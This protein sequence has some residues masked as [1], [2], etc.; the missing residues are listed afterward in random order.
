M[1]KPIKPSAWNKYT[2]A[3][4]YHRAGF[5]P[6]PDDIARALAQSPDDAV[7]ELVNIQD[8]P[9]SVNPPTWLKPESKMR[10]PRELM[11]QMSEEERKKA[12]MEMRQEHQ[13]QM[14]EL[15]GWWLDRMLRSRRQLQEKL[16]LFWHGHFATSMEKV[17]S[18]YCLYRQNE[19]FRQHANGSWRTL[20]SELA[21][22]PA[23][24]IYLDNA[25]S[26]K[27]HPNENFAR[28]LME[29][30][31]LGEGHYTEQDIK[32]SARAFTGWALQRDEFEFITRY[33]SHD[34]GEKTFF[35]QT[36]H[37][38][39]NDI[40]EII[41]QQPEAPRFI[42]R[43]L[44]RFF[45]AENPDPKLVDALAEI[46]KS[47]NFEFRPVLHALL[48]SEEF[49]ASDVMGSQ[50]KSPVQ[51]L[52]GTARMAGAN[53]PPPAGSNAI[54][55]ALGQELFAP[56][57]VKGWDG[58]FAWISTTRLINRYN[59][60]G[61]LVKGAARNEIKRW[62]GRLG[63]IESLPA[64]IDSGTFL[65]AAERATIAKAQEFL[66]WRVYGHRIRPKDSAVL[67][68]LIQ[69]MPPPGQW[70]D[71]QVRGVVHLMLST[72]QYQLC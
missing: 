18:P 34:D 19:L 2:A 39:G 71:E 50:V 7:A 22:D 69:A 43:K 46:L 38:D 62:G 1:L 44:W 28:E 57:N 56:P 60:A 54:L 16:T 3:H 26:Q 5:G 12:Q 13:E 17:R 25:Q 20:L 6:T 70:T 29:L 52:V 35:G 14:R 11:K 32:E 9:E 65:P 67:A 40:I 24:L 47:N 10:P 30:F 48:L 66:E 23:M 45:A 15:R 63:G 4:L 27:A 8:L 36:G 72:P 41:L 55:R 49:Y 58:G 37:W 51:W 33:P 59:F 42:V 64:A 53:L 61:A 21:R 31:T 68:D